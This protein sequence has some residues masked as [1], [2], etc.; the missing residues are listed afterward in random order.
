MGVNHPHVKF[1]EI[2]HFHLICV[3][4]HWLHLLEFLILLLPKWLLLVRRHLFNCP[5]LLCHPFNND[6][7]RRRTFI[8]TWMVWTLAS[9]SC[10]PPYIFWFCIYFIFF[11]TAGSTAGSSAGAA[12][13]TLASLGTLQGLAGSSVGLNNLNALTSSV[14]GKN[15]L[16]NS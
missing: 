2:P 16:S 15:L 10:G 5:S 11:L 6:K 12:M 13:N 8:L 14:S 3:N 1:Y 9:C 4:I 7:K